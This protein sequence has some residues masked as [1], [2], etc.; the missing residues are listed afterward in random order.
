M[1]RDTARRGRTAEERDA[2][3]A[4]LEAAARDPHQV[5][6]VQASRRPARTSI[7]R[8]RRARPGRPS[9]TTARDGPTPTPATGP[10]GAARRSRRSTRSGAS[11][12]AF[13]IAARS[14][15]TC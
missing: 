5:A 11:S 1:S 15:T 12:S 13:C 14:S 7:R 2:A 8:A 10:A 6:R 3:L 4:W 9:T